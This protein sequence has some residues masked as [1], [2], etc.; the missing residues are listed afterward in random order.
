MH[1]DGV[2]KI[3]IGECGKGVFFLKTGG[4]H[5]VID[6]TQLSLSELKMIIGDN[7]FIV[8]DRIIQ[9]DSIS[10][11]YS[12]SVN[13]LRIITGRDKSGT[14]R[15]IDTILRIGAHGNRVDNWAKGGI[16]VSVNDAGRLRDFGTYEFVTDGKLRTHCHPDTGVIFKDYQIP[17]YHDAIDTV[18]R[19]HTFLYG[20]ATIGWDVAITP[21]GPVIIEGNDNYE[22]SLNQA[23]S[24]P[25]RQKWESVFGKDWNRHI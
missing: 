5:I 1:I 11:L 10:R 22:I 23:P 20:I 7:I 13:T 24:G 6:D 12:H 25:L 2:A 8:Q 19:L 17:F 15:H 21:D 16:A 18:I 14:V 3:S 4:K 9:H